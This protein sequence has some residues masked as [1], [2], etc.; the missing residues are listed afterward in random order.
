M[1]VQMEH[2][3]GRT[4]AEHTY[5]SWLPMAEE[6]KTETQRFHDVVGLLQSTWEDRNL[7]KRDSTLKWIS[8]ISTFVRTKSPVAFADL[9]VVVRIGLDVILQTPDNL[10]IQIRWAQLLTKILRKFRKK[11]SLTVEWR[12]LFNIVNEVHFKRRQSYEGLALK[13]IHLEQ[14]TSLVRRCRRFFPSDAAVEIWNEFRPAFDDLSHNSALEAVGFI[15]LFLPSTFGGRDATSSLLTRDWVVEA[16]R[17]WEAMPNCRF[18]TFQWASLMSRVIKDSHVTFGDWEDFVPTLFTFYLQS[19]EVPVGRASASSPVQREINRE[20]MVAFNSSWSFST[21][22]V[23]AKS[24]VYLIKPSGA[25]LHELEVLVDLLEQYY[26]PSNGGSWTSSLEQF[27]KHLVRYFLKRLSQQRGRESKEQLGEKERSLFVKAMLRLIDR[28]QYSKT[29]ALASTA[30]SAASALAFVEPY[31][32]LPLLVSRFFSAMD[33][34]TATHQLQTAVTSLALVSRPILLA[35]AKEEATGHSPMLDTESATSFKDTLVMAMFS[36]LMGLDANDPPKTL[37]TMQF[38][39]SV[40][41]SIG[42]LGDESDGGSTVLPLDWSQWLNEFLSRL[43]TLLVH[44]EPSSQ[45]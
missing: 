27:L 23:N 41:S 6:I 36:T 10:F 17:T 11:L 44:L 39:C 3:E 16:I 2:D 35:S 13:Q 29:P 1:D 37:A 14:I 4:V 18:W 26:H 9:E 8:L 38:Y 30:A 19:F 43:F 40:L 24:M 7:Q 33:T 45:S 42:V 25:A 15:N 31:A 21:S 5:N 34:I 22:I 12:P 28:G 32:V 20:I